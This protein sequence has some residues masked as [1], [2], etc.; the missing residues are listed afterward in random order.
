MSRQEAHW[1]G[2]VVP[3]KENGYTE[4]DRHI[5]DGHQSDKTTDRRE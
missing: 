4:I 5:V 1:C 2:I 3:P